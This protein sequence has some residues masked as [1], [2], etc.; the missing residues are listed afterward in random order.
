M[1]PTRLQLQY[2][3]HRSNESFQEYAQR[4]REMASRVRPTL[5]NIELVDIFMRTLQILYYEKMVGSSSS[6]FSY[7]VITRERIESGLKTGK[8]IGGSS[9]QSVVR[10]PSSGYA[11]KKEGNTNAVIISVLHYQVHVV[12]PSYYPYPYVAATQ[13]QQPFQY[14]PQY[15]QLPKAQQQQQPQGQAP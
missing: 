15:Q 13:F 11:K 7:L 4:W 9:Q 6:N 12:P 10:R 5:T 14:Q 2:Q 3:A 8:I 1:V